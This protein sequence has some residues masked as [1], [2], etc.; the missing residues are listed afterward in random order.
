MC[1]VTKNIALY[2]KNSP[3]KDKKAIK[4]WELLTKTSNFAAS[5]E[6]IYRISIY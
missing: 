1:K 2:D 4:I 3:H 6:T 5:F